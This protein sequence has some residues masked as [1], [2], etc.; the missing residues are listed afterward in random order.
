MKYIVTIIGILLCISASVAGFTVRDRFGGDE[1][2]SATFI[3]S[4]TNTNYTLNPDLELSSLTITNESLYINGN[5]FQFIS[6][7][8]T[9]VYAHLGQILRNNFLVMVTET[10][11]RT[12]ATLG[13]FTPGKEY[14]V[15]ISENLFLTEIPDTDGNIT[16]SWEW[17]D[18]I[19]DFIL[20]S[21]RYDINLDSYVNVFDL[22]ECWANRWELS[23]YLG[24]YDVNQDLVVNVLDLSIIWANS[25]Y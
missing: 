5:I 3:P 16:F 9:Y 4:S 21:I 15:D 18:T 20:I 7:N 23:P 14:L 13:G 19:A 12:T 2:T 17:N 22:S 1:Y 11:N 10:S 8:D 25:G 24:R 6:E